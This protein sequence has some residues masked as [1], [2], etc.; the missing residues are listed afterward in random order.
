MYIGLKNGGGLGCWVPLCRRS[1]SRAGR[2]R[3]GGFPEHAREQI[4]GSDVAGSDETGFRVDGRLHWVHCARTG[5]YTLL[6][7]HPRRGKQA[8]EAMGVLPSS[9][10]V[11][12]HDTWAPYDSYPAA[13]HQPCCAHARRE[14]QAVT[15]LAPERQWCWATQ[16]ADAPTTMQKLVSE[17]ISQGRDAAD[18]AAIDAQSHPCRS[19]AP[20]GASQT[21]ARSSP[22][23]KST[24]RW[25]AACRTARTTTC[26]SPG[27]SGF[28][29]TTTEPSATSAWPS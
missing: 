5:K 22:P 10:G 1:R 18:P 6:M 28:P 25:P 8:I 11:A 21:A 26:G 20:L 7:V 12:V 2:G 9:G 27:T 23:M 16:A 24:T 17:T 4:A 3:L 15:D 29:R 13:G 19:A 14:L